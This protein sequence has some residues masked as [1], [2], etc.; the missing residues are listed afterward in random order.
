MKITKIQ[1]IV[2]L[3]TLSVV[4]ISCNKTAVIN[5]GNLQI[6][7]DKNLYS[8][9]KSLSDNTDVFNESFQL[10]DYLETKN[11]QTDRFKVYEVTSHSLEGKFGAGTETILKGEFHKTNIC[12]TKIISVKTYSEYPDIAFFNVSYVNCGEQDLLVKKWINH[13]YRILAQKESPGFWAFQGSSSGRRD[14]WIKPVNP[15][16]FQKNFMGMNDSDYGGGI[17]VTDLWRKDGGIAIGHIELVPKEISLPVDF[18][19]YSDYARIWLEKEYDSPFKLNIGDTLNTLSTFVSVHTGDYYSSLQLYSE[20]M[21][22]NGIDSAEREEDAFES[23]WCGWGYGRK[24]TTA[25]IINTLPKVKELGIKWAVIDDGYQI[26]EGDWRVDTKRFPGGEKDMKKMVD[27]IH[28]YGLKAKIWWAPL[29]ADPG[30]KV[31]EENPDVLLINKDGAPQYITWWDSYY[32][33][34]ASEATIVHTKETVEMFLKDWGFD[35]LKIDGQHLNAVPA[36]YNWDRPLEYPEKSIEMLP[37][38]FKMI[39]ET[40]RKIKPHAVIEICPCGTCMSF[41]NMPYANQTVASDPESSWQIRLKGKTYKAIIPQTAYYGDHV[42]LSD[43]G[44]DFASSFGVGAVL[45]TKFTWPKDNPNQRRSHLLTPEREE[46][47]KKW[48]NLYHEKMLSRGKYL[49]NLYDIGYDKPETHVIVKSD[50]MYYAFY[51]ENW[52]G[53]IELRGLEDKKYRVRDYY[54]DNDLGTVNGV[55]AKIDVEFNKFLLLEVFQEK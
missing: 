8:K 1:K 19:K 37:E 50:T 18:D 39:Y 30:S 32:M 16:Y 12:L 43:N 44:T 10:S 42:E 26:A 27:A 11:F 9:V 49:G 22:K 34:P 2:F 31:I 41:Y 48:F 14:D 17:P 29:A 47:W 20:F 25:D 6:K 33:S 51:D 55:N 40:A 24:F 5:S 38:F 4:F 23:I 28:S 54:N 13:N 35:G 45:G 7:F 52:K 3:I 46:I 36:D 21:Q 15:G 53:L